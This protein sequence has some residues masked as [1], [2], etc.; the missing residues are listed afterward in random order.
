[1]PSIVK[2]KRPT[3]KYEKEWMAR[4]HLKVAGVDEAG[5]G[6][7]AG[8]VSVAAVIL[9]D[10]FKHRELNDSKQ[11]KESMREKIYEELMTL[12]DLIW[13]VIL[14]DVEEI[15]RINILQ[16]TRMGMRRVVQALSVVP[17]VA[18][19]DGLK[20]PDFPIQQQALV[21]GDSLSLSIAAASVIAKVTRDRYMIEAAQQYPQYEFHQHKG[22]GTPKHLAALRLHGP[23][24]IHRRSFAPV[25]QLNLAFD[26]A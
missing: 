3:L 18:L 5:R 10:G 14:L 11:L 19:I 17:D 8:P 20:V 12:P 4:G 7:L 2:I 16:A 15:D 6:P 23:C 13:S 22:Y 9:P 24:P 26:A 1:M 21:K 25:S